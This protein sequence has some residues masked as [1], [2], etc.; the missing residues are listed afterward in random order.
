[1]RNVSKRRGSAKRATGER[2]SFPRTRLGG[3]AFEYGGLVLDATIQRTVTGRADFNAS[4]RGGHA[5]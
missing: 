5:T 2:M 4:E 3:S 1:V